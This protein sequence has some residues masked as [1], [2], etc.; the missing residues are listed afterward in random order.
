MLTREQKYFLT[1]IIVIK[2][3]GI[4]KLIRRFLWA[5]FFNGSL[6]PF[7]KKGIHVYNKIILRLASQL[8]CS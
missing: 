4:A 2:V 6:R 3:D 8:L 1:Q 7:E 5:A